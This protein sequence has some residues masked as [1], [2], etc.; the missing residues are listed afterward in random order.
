MKK[1]FTSTKYAMQV[2]HYKSCSGLLALAAFALATPAFALNKV[3][4]TQDLSGGKKFSDVASNLDD[5]AQIGASLIISVVAVVGYV[6][7]ALSLY[8]LWRASKEDREH[9]PLAAIIGLFIGGAM[10]A[11]GTIMWIMRN[12]VIGTSTAT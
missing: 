5:A 4:L 6:V 7:V 3:D 12:T 9:K 2:A 10:A 11:V 1:F 8:S